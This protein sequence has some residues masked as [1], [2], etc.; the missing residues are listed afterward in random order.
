MNKL[1]VLGSTG[2]LGSEVCRIL[3][4]RGI[5]YVTQHDV[6]PIVE[7]V[8]WVLNC[9]GI[10]IGKSPYDMVEA[11]VLVPMWLAKA[12]PD[13]KKVFV[14]TDCVFSGYRPLDTPNK[15]SDVP[16]PNTPYGCTKRVGEHFADLVIRTSFIG[17][18]HG[19]LRWAID[20]KDQQIDGYANALWNGSTVDVIADSI[21]W[22]M[23]GNYSGI[24]H[25]G[26]PFPI[27]KFQL[28]TIINE[29]FG[30]GLDTTVQLTPRINRWLEPTFVIK[31][32][33]V[34]SITKY[35][36]TSKVVY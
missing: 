31:E 8:K 16:D 15:I 22:M 12:Y 3:N 19:L 13:A 35:C 25:L 34:N 32:G 20:N 11:N 21:L 5:E 10:I 7:D 14:S 18:K 6:Y 36:E 1:L 30:L 2:M 33:L 4:E 17:L 24:H 29:V 26:T 28:L 27:N 23:F 9:A